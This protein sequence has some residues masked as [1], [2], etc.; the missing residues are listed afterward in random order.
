M[1]TAQCPLRPRQVRLRKLHGDREPSQCRGM[2]N[3]TDLGSV[4]SAPLAPFA[5]Q[6]RLAVA[7][8][9]ARFT[10]ISRKARQGRPP[11]TAPEAGHSRGR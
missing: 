7:A 9:L 8:Y 2:L 1:R 3:L 4:P 6:L 10:G 5:D 11:G